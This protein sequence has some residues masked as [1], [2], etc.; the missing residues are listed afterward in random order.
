M[1]PATDLATLY[2]SD[3][4][5]WFSDTLA[6]LRSGNFAEIDIIHLIEEIEG[7]AGRDRNEVESRL[8]VLLAHLLKR[9]YVDSPQDYRGWEGT[10]RGQRKQLRRLFKHS[11]SLRRYAQQVLP[12]VWQDALMDVQ[13]DYPKVAFPAEWPFSP[14]IDNLLTD[15]FW[16]N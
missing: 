8:D 12:E 6:K 9:L 13:A 4:A 10:V 11:P 2:D 1:T 7:L 14:A 5:L 3:L 15:S 16:V